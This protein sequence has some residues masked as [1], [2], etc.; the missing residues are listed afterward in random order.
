[1]TCELLSSRGMIVVETPNPHFGWIMNSNLR[2]DFQTAYQIIVSSSPEGRRKNRIMWNS[3]KVLSGNSSNVVY[4]GSRLSP[5][6]RYSWKVRIWDRKHHRSKFSESQTFQT[7]TFTVKHLTSTHAVA[8]HHIKPRRIVKK[9]DDHF[10]IDFGKDAFGSLQVNLSKNRAR[11]PVEVRLGEKLVDPATLDSAPPATIR[12]YRAMI[13]PEKQTDGFLLKLP[14]FEPPPWK[15]KPYDHIAVARQIG[16]V[17][18]F[19]YCEISNY[20]GQITPDDVAQLAAYYPFD[21]SASFFESSSEILNQVWEV[22]KHTIKATTFCGIYVDG[23]RERKPYEADAYI[24]QL[25]HYNVDREYA[26]G[27]YSY[28]YFF[29]NPSWPTE[30]K[31][32]SIFMA[33]MDYLYTGDNRSISFFYEQLKRNKLLFNPFNGRGLLVNQDSDDNRDIVDWPEGERDRY[34]MGEVNLVPN[35]FYYR[36]LRIMSKIA[37]VLN[38][39]ADSM[40]FLGMAARLKKTIEISFLNRE[41][42]VFVD[43]LGSKH[44][45]LHANLFPLAFGLVPGEL[46]TAVIDFIKE[47]RM[48]CS[49]YAAQYL[50]EALYR[51]AEEDYALQ[52]LTSTEKRSW[53]NMLRSGST[54]TLEAWDLAYKPNLDWNHPWGAVPANVIPRCL[55]GI[56]PMDPGF[57]K[58]QIKPQTASLEFTR[59]RVPT[60]RGGVDAVVE[61]DLRRRY[62]Y[63]FK[64]PANTTAIATLPIHKIE[65]PKISVNGRQAKNAISGNLHCLE[66]PS[67]ESRIEIS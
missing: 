5:V 52:L 65:N 15:K 54:M 18:P 19:R 50:L 38:R 51:E 64:I 42:G 48:A 31:F 58:I 26:L 40:E 63:L 47:K 56:Q 13:P 22:C 2:G 4:A 45:S 34:D 59:I 1:L 49:V 44:S 41:T 67:G 32:H 29:T 37:G 36:A 55:W 20:R 46:K 21:D 11:R 16:N 30:W 10:F 33:W 12:T 7:G 17:M 6:T 27:R 53:W 35:A 60:L 8:L 14:D 39:S 3:G 62:T 43:S 66:L 57:S 28:E 61:T 24:N 25:G 9:T 23:D